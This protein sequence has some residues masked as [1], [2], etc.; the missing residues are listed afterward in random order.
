MSDLAVGLWIAAECLF[1]NFELSTRSAS[2]VLDLKRIVKVWTKVFA[3]VVLIL[4]RI[5][6][7]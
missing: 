2:S 4:V 3:A 5:C 1:Q 7:R 6:Y